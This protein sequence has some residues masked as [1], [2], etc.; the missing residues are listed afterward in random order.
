MI[1]DGWEYFPKEFLQMFECCDE[2]RSITKTIIFAVKNEFCRIRSV[3]CCYDDSWIIN[4]IFSLLAFA[5]VS[6]FRRSLCLTSFWFLSLYVLYFILCD[7]L[8]VSLSV[9]M[10]ISSSRSGLSLTNSTPSPSHTS[11]TDVIG[12]GTVFLNFIPIW[13]SNKL[14]TEW[15]QNKLLT[16]V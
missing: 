12:F 6:R 15:F 11:K 5:Y 10:Y 9:S 16:L 2:W 3:E 8:D 4:I 1:K 13:I 7:S 14:I